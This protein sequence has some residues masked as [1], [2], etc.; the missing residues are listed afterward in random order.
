MVIQSRCYYIHVGKLLL[1]AP[2]SCLCST[3]DCH[4]DYMHEVKG[5]SMV[6][7]VAP[8]LKYMYQPNNV[9]RTR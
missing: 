1:G 7:D 2:I 5:D 3:N 9:H 6:S 4:L 8:G